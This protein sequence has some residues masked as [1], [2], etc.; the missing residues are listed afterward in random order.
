MD[1]FNKNKT[2]LILNPSWY[3]GGLFSPP[4]TKTIN[5]LNFA[6]KHVFEFFDNSNQR[7]RQLLVNFYFNLFGGV[8]P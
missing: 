6:K 7:F 1:V 3:G 4:F 5:A 8:P 2:S